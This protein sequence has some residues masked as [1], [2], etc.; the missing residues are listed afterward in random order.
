MKN[1]S[2]NLQ[3]LNKQRL[4]QELLHDLLDV[5]VERLVI[6]RVATQGQGVPQSILIQLNNAT[7]LRYL[8]LHLHIQQQRYLCRIVL[9]HAIP[10]LFLDGKEDH[11]EGGVHRDNY[12]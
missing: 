5:T 7:M 10:L 9:H 2:L 1:T 4:N 6:Q 8:P 11:L 3:L 12:E